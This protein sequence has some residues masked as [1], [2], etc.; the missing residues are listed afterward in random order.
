MPP[1]LSILDASVQYAAR[2]VVELDIQA[3]MIQGTVGLR[4][5]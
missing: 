3:E 2:N 5:K 4:V 1:E